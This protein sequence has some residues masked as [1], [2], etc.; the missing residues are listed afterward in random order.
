VKGPSEQDECT[1]KPQIRPLPDYY[2][3]QKHL[4][5][6]PFE[7][8]V[9]QWNQHRDAV[10]MRQREKDESKE[11]RGLSLPSALRAAVWWRCAHWRQR[12]FVLHCLGWAFILRVLLFPVG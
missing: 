2:G 11:V 10:L 8:R 9:K 12:F 3:S 6:V 7:Q 5:S 1:F 4:D